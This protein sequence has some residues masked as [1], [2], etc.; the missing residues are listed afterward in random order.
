MSL[1]VVLVLALLL[2][3]FPVYGYDPLDP[4]GNITI[5]W[6]VI[7]SDPDHKIRVSIF[8]YQLFRHV[9]QP[10]WKLRWSWHG[11][12]VI[13]DMR[14]A[15][16]TEQGDCSAV[17]GSPHCCEKEP[18]IVDLLPGVPYNMQTANC[19]KGG[20]L[21]SM[22]QDPGKYGASFEMGIGS[23]SDDGSGP[24]IPEN[25]T[26]GIP[27][28]TCGQPF[29]VPPSKFSVDKGRR[30]T[31]AVA[32]WDVICTYSQY[33][34]SSSPTCCVSLS[35]FYSKTIVP[36]SICSCGCQGQLAANQ[37][38][39]R[40]EVPPVLQL[41]NN[42]PPKPVL[43]CTQHM[44]PIQVHWHVKQSYTQYWR[45][46]MTIRNFNYVR[47]YSQ[48]NLVVLHPNLR[49]V[50]QVFSFNYKPLDQYGDINDTGMFYGIQYYNDMLL[51][52]GES[53]VVQSELLLHKDAGI[54]SFKEGWMFPRRISFNGHECV[55][56]PS[57]EYP[58]LPNTSQ[59]LAPS[60]LTI[61]V[62]SL[63]LI[64]AIFL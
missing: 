57:D 59:F 32:T 41:D 2:L 19:C 15:E 52:A 8:N 60:I 48:W 61:I 25:F 37:C 20:V 58:M 53:G 10:G 18:V 21:T 1:G 13:W 17:R 31:Q 47:N 33:R 51:Q 9:E 3:I 27:G 12:E 46:K 55:V 16:T 64:L 62:F 22:T 7:Q 38:V 39:K 29:P 50:T 28:Y 36:C 5:K 49:S 40:G 35:A 54:F 30:K 24:R 44:C 34:A 42:E 23:A 43:E 26:L 11:K 14:G 45:V 56:P 6:D 63:L 4:T